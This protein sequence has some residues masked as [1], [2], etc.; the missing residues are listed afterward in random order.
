MKK[1]EENTMNNE[2][3]QQILKLME[4]MIAY[5]KKAVAV[6]T[7]YYDNADLKKMFHISDSTLHRLRK[8]GVIEYIKIGGKYFYR[9]SFIDSAF[10]K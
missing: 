4:L 10:I 6:E 3:M 5:V 7:I 9:K 8:Q 1:I 2:Q